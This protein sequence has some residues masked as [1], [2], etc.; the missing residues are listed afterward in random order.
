MARQRLDRSFLIVLLMTVAIF[1][2]VV[3]IVRRWQQS[4]QTPRE[5]AVTTSITR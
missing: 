5:P 3:L 1:V 4:A 2:A